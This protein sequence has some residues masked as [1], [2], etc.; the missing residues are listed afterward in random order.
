MNWEDVPSGVHFENYLQAPSGLFFPKFLSY[1]LLK[2]ISV[3]AVH[4]TSF[5]WRKRLDEVNETEINCR[6]SLQII[7]RYMIIKVRIGP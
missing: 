5:L 6:I 7:H 2:L 4:S 3:F 1:C